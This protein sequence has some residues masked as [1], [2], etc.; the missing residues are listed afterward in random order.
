[1]SAELIAKYTSLSIDEIENLK[2]VRIIQKAT[3]EQAAYAVNLSLTAR[4]WLVG[5][6]T[7]WS[8]NSMVKTVPSMA[9]NY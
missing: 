6:I 3:Q 4:N 9:T 7:S 2:I 5:D 1:M 8:M